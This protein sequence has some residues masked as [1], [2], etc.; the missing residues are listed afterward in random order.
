M[1][2]GVHTVLGNDRRPVSQHFNGTRKRPST[3]IDQIRTR[4]R[5]CDVEWEHRERAT[6]DGQ[7]RLS[8]LLTSTLKGVNEQEDAF[9]ARSRTDRVSSLNDERT[10]F[11]NFCAE[12]CANATNKRET[13]NDLLQS[14]SA[15]H[16]ELLKLRQ[17]LDEMERASYRFEM[18]LPDPPVPVNDKPSPVVTQSGADDQHMRTM[19]MMALLKNNL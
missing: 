11:H 12:F 15:T 10:V 1:K 8:E 6:R 2:K 13:I 7:Q 3:V 18:E 19:L 5:E 14:S 16:N 17:K 9:R 4:N